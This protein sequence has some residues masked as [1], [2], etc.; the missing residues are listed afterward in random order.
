MKEKEIN[1]QLAESIIKAVNMVKE[2]APKI[3]KTYSE[4][5][6]Y[7]S[8]AVVLECVNILMKEHGKG[9]NGLKGKAKKYYDLV[10]KQIKI[11]LTVLTSSCFKYCQDMGT[12][13]IPTL[14]FNVYC[15]QIIKSVTDEK[16]TNSA[17]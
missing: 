6:T 2:A 10:Q 8:L 9:G 12:K 7:V 17:A 16:E 3:T 14:I 5:D 4:Q 11:F 1:P 13:N 15:E